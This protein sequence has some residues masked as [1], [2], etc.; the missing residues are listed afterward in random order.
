MN[1]RKKIGPVVFATGLFIPVVVG[2]VCYIL[3]LTNDITPVKAMWAI[4][5]GAIVGF[6]LVIVGVLLRAPPQV[7]DESNQPG[8]GQQSLIASGAGTEHVVDSIHT[9]DDTIQPD[10][11]DASREDVKPPAAD[12]P[13]EEWYQWFDWITSGSSTKPDP[14]EVDAPRDVWFHWYHYV[15]DVQ[16]YRIGLKEL[17][18]KL[19]LSHNTVKP[20][21]SNYQIQYRDEEDNEIVPE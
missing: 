9:G 15:K 2:T 12:A 6:I 13:R 10:A 18:E 14:P 7:V 3:A 17:A 20:L 8:S 19:G 16:G 21:H 5:G 1:L 4:V 11:K